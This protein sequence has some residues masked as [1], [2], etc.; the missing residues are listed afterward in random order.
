MVRAH[1]ASER[2][3][4]DGL[5]AVISGEPRLAE[6]L[7]QRALAVTRAAA[8]TPLHAAVQTRVTRHARADAV[9]AQAVPGAVLRTR[10]L[11]VVV[12]G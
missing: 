6:A 2:G 1:A 11:K 3:A 8:R 7:A 9:R 10:A 12:F 4:G 5:L